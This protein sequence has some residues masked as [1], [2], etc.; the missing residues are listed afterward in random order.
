MKYLYFVTEIL[1]FPMIF[2]STLNADQTKHL[3][4][5]KSKYKFKDIFDEIS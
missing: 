3:E 4:L 2:V 5:K 1:V